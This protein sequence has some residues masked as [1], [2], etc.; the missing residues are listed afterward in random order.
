MIQQKLKESKEKKPKFTAAKKIDYSKSD[1]SLYSK[2]GA[3]DNDDDAATVDDKSNKALDES[4]KSSSISRK[5][6]PV[7]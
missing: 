7:K 2:I 5:I 1:M 6:N 4:N 3:I